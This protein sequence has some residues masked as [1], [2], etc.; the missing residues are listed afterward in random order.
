MTGRHTKLTPEV[1]DRIVAAIA[2]GNTRAAAAEHGPVGERTLYRW[3]AKGEH[4][5]NGSPCGQLWQD[6]KKAEN[7]AEIASV[8]RIRQAAQGGQLT[9]REVT[10]KELKD[11]TTV[12]TTKEAYTRPE[13]TADAW[14]LER[15][16]EQ[17]RRRENLDVT[18]RREAERVAKESGLDVEE[19]V[20]EAER[21][22]GSGATS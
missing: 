13:W 9:H 20:K 17:W 8:A 16:R 1:H 6:V 4:S 3:L 18:I 14:W 5:R 7:E 10:V 15:R 12:T 21:L 22:L 19:V 11:G 2:A